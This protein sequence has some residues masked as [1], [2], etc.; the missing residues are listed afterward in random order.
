MGWWP[1]RPSSHT[2]SSPLPR[3]STRTS[4]SPWSSRRGGLAGTN[5]VWNARNPDL[6]SPA[7]KRNHSRLSAKRFVLSPHQTFAS[8]HLPGKQHC[9]TSL[10]HRP[11]AEPHPA[12]RSSPFPPTRRIPRCRPP[13]ARRRVPG[14]AGE[15]G[16][17]AAAA[18]GAGAAGGDHG[19]EGD[20][21]RGCATDMPDVTDSVGNK[22]SDLG[23]FCTGQYIASCAFCF[24]F[25]V[26]C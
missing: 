2:T 10:G 11:S 19:E 22:I 4:G 14:A 3:S 6:P 18:E 12:C 1:T 21:G 23:S 5:S 25:C 17:A 7:A 26:F 24:F 20:R 16:A 13:E 9:V 15:T 8:G